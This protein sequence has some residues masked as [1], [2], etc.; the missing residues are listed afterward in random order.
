MEERINQL[1]KENQQLKKENE[2]LSKV[3]TDFKRKVKLNLK[4]IKQYLREPEISEHKYEEYREKYSI[5]PSG[6]PEE[7]I[8]DDS[9]EELEISEWNMMQSFPKIEELVKQRMHEL[10][11]ADYMLGQNI[12]Q[13]NNATNSEW[14]VINTIE[15]TQEVLTNYSTARKVIRII[16]D[17]GED[18]LYPRKEKSKEDIS[19]I[20]KDLITYINQMKEYIASIE[21]PDLWLNEEIQKL[22]EWK[23]M[24][25]RINGE[26]QIRKGI[27]FP[28]WDEDDLGQIKD[29]WKDIKKLINTLRNQ[30]RLENNPNCEY[31]INQWKN[32]A[33]SLEQLRQQ[34][35]NCECYYNL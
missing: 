35:E 12:E 31:R 13:I 30:P 33:L 22:N 32:L 4:N 17:E 29:N 16:M 6:I 5:N 11:M 21:K 20:W 23:E 14:K 10:N 15:A 34:Y 3:F 26:F 25:Q 18:I 9:E 1:L 24:L 27:I 2:K 19:L 8:S 28:I 7:I